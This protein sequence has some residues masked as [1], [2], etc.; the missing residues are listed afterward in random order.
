MCNMITQGF[1][2]NSALELGD[3]PTV[4]TVTG[5]GSWGRLAEHKHHTKDRGDAARGP[6]ALLR[7]VRAST[8]PHAHSPACVAMC[9]PKIG[10]PSTIALK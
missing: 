10:A 3:Q 7:A 6:A 4:G 2:I 5:L 8:H 9:Q 1:P